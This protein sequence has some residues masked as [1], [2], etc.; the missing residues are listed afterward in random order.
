MPHFALQSPVA[1]R[2]S[3]R[4]RHLSQAP[5]RCASGRAASSASTIRSHAARIARGVRLARHDRPADFARVARLAGGSRTDLAGY[6][7]DGAEHGA[8]HLRRQLAGVGVVARAVKAVEQRQPGLALRGARRVRTGSRLACSSADS[9]LSW[10][11]RPSARI[12]RRR[13]MAAMRLRQKGPA[14]ARSPPASACF[15]RH[16]AHGVGDQAVDQLQPVVGPRLVVSAREAEARAASRTAGR[17]Q[18]RR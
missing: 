18:N 11:M 1:C 7:R 15:G 12:A 9:V 16:A 13:G 5:R 8:K 2:H 14:G 3:D 17:R 10:A 6:A 4:R